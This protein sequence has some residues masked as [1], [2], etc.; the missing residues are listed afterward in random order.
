MRL[1]RYIAVSLLAVVVISAMACGWPPSKSDEVLLYRIM[2]LD[3]PDYS[4]Y[5]DVWDCDWSLRPSMYAIYE[6][7]MLALW[8]RQ[9]SNA[10][11]TEDIKYVVYQAD[12]SYLQG[13]RQKT[14]ESNGFARWLIRNRR[15]DI[16]D[17]LILA[18][19]CEKVVFSKEDPWYYGVDG[20]KQSQVLEGIVAKCKAY[21]KGPLLS[22]YTLQW[23]RALCAQRKYRECVDVWNNRK[24]RLADDAVKKVAE[25]RAACAMNKVGNRQEALK[26][27]AKYGD[28]ASIRTINDGSIDNELEYVYNLQPNSPY[29]MGELQKWLIYF[30]TAQYNGTVP[31]I[32][33]KRIS[34]IIK[35]AKKAVRNRAT[36]NK[37]MWYY[38]LAALY[39]VQG[40]TKKAMSY[41]D[42]GDLCPKNQFLRDSYHVL[43]M[44]FDA[45]TAKYDDA[46]EQ[47]LFTDLKWLSAKIENNAPDNFREVINEYARGY[48][49]QPNTFY[50]NDALRRLVFRE[51]C[52][53]MHKASRYIR[54]VQ[55]ANMAENLLVQTC[56]YSNEMFQ[57]MDRQSYLQTKEYFNR[58]YHPKDDFDKFLNSKGKVTM[59]YWYDIL[60]T[61]CIREQRYAKAIVYLRQIP[62]NFQK[63]MPV[64]SYM[65]K[66]P[67]SYDMEAF[68]HEPL[69]AGNCKL[70]FAER[71]ARYKQTMRYNRNPNKRADAKIIYAMGLRNS[72]HRCWFLTRYSS[73]WDDTYVM[74]YLPEIAY[75]NDTAVYRHDEYMKQ[76]ERLINQAFKAYTNK[77]MIARQL[78]K[79]LYFRKIMEKYGDTETARDIRLHCDRWRDYV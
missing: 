20:D 55:L 1:K 37:A 41:L 56:E 8:R 3:E 2:P 62:L 50:W 31:E 16:I 47:R 58:I 53:R 71:M 23:M 11:S 70:H 48:Q 13:L 51:V 72:V 28:V 45:K 61:K 32:S 69:L 12:I 77:E 63:K 39:D 43:H 38:S 57:I 36:K 10:I 79:M 21:H 46:Y 9:T 30:G 54:E 75:P 65:N 24:S 25:L 33:S 49:D 74:D 5:E 22:R 60:A 52:P 67:F 78:R 44:W 29:L 26:I 76:S 18:K 15:Y 27:Y 73:N 19:Q 66:D 14:D 64:F 40:N 6:D 17:Y 7:E 34:G 59:Y 35:V 68:R 42:K 4:K